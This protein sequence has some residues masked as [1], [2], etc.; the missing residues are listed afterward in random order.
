MLTSPSLYLN[1]RTKAAPHHPAGGRRTPPNSGMAW[2]ENAISHP[3]SS[4]KSTRQPTPTPISADAL[5]LEG[6]WDLAPRA[7]ALCCPLKAD[8]PREI[9]SP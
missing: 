2:H 4:S 1:D 3:A 8:L 9:W 7:D 5:C 6:L